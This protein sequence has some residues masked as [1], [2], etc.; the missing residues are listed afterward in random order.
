MADENTVV[1]GAEPA[2]TTGQAGAEPVAEADEKKAAPSTEPEQPWHKDPRFKNE[3]GLLKAAKTLMEKNGLESVEDLVE[4]A[5]SGKKVHGKQIDLDHLDEIAA[6][7]KKLEE[8]EAY[9]QHEAEMKRR[10]EEDPDD[11]VKRLEK[12]LK[13]HRD[14][15]AR[16]QAQSRQVEDTRRAIDS[17]ESEVKSL[18]SED[19]PK[20]QR[21]FVAEFFG[22]GNPCNDIDITDKKAVRRLVAEGIKKKEAYD[23]AVIKNYLAAKGEIPK[24]ASSA[25]AAT[26]ETKPKTMLKDA[27]RMFIEQMQKASGG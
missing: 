24:L 18:L 16:K 15:E 26:T 7:A 4:L 5:E 14:Q 6:K 19:I 8:Y 23:Q 25:G 9:W 10:Q 13:A 21:A 20:E 1:A 17:Y 3:L 2:D 27:R 22:V 12:E 11:T